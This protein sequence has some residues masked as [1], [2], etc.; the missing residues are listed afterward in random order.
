MISIITVIIFISFH[1]AVLS[2]DNLSLWEHFNNVFGASVVIEAFGSETA[3]TSSVQAQD[4]QA[5]QNVLTCFD[6]TT[7][8]ELGTFRL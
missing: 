8:Q 1:S 2:V 4:I 3:L 5:T 6:Y 7:G